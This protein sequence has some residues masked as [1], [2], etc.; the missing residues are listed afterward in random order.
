MVTTSTVR[1]S[2]RLMHAMD[3][4]KT[5]VNVGQV[6][7]LASE[8]G[9]GVLILAGLM[10]GGVKGLTIAALGGGLLYRGATGHCHLYDALGANTAAGDEQGPFDS[11]PARRGVKVEESIT[12]GRSPEE[13][14]RYWRD[15]TNLPKFME[16]IASVSEIGHDRTH[17]VMTAPLGLTL[18]WDSEIYNDKP[19]ELIAWRSLEGAQVDT[20]GSV[21]FIAAPGGRGTEV[22]VSQ[23][24]NPPGGKASVA[25]AKLFGQDPANQTRGNLRRLKQILEAGEIATVK[26]QPSG[27]RSVVH[28]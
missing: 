15:Y 18:E 16:N 9:G 10:H 27:Y 3:E 12:I 4:G 13:V 11:V 21:H 24:M 23:K 22:R 8:V 14:Y 20:A 19:G 7:R 5:T 25:L 17:W 26:G 2:Q 1:A 6:E 28:I